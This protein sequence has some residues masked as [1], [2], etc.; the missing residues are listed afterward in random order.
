MTDEIASM[1][2]KSK[3][4]CDADRVNLVAVGIGYLDFLE[5]KFKL[6]NYFPCKNH[7]DSQLYG[8]KLM[9]LDTPRGYVRMI[10]EKS[11]AWLPY[12]GGEG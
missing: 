10:D 7:S 3:M 12:A 4:I 2:V 8:V 5:L 6:P 11:I 1:I 9:I